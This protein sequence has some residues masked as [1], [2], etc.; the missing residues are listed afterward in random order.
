VDLLKLLVP[1]KY[2]HLL[3][4]H[5]G[6]YR[7]IKQCS[8]LH[9][10]LELPTVYSYTPGRCAVRLGALETRTKV[11]QADSVEAKYDST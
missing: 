3:A 7:L 4:I 6:K 2:G 11:G 8:R 9:D 10:L 5:D 1:F